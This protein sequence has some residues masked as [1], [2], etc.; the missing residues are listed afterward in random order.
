LS[1]AKRTRTV[2]TALASWRVAHTIKSNSYLGQHSC[3][4]IGRVAQVLTITLRDG[5]IVAKVAFAQK[6]ESYPQTVAER[7]RNGV[8][9][10]FD[11]PN[12]LVNL[13]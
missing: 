11:A 7:L 8:F 5:F 12:L 10:K 4:F 9:T 13:L 3:S 2:H 1:K 6:R